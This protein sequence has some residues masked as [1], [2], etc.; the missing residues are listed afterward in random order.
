MK[1]IQQKTLYILKIIR[2][3]LVYRPILFIA[4]SLGYN[5]VPIVKV[6]KA[7]T[8]IMNSFSKP[9]GNLSDERRKVMLTPALEFINKESVLSALNKYQ[10]SGFFI[11]PDS[12]N[13]LRFCFLDSQRL[14]VAEAIATLC[15]DNFYRLRYKV[16]SKICETISFAKLAEDIHYSNRI[17]FRLISLRANHEFNF[18]VEFWTEKNDHYMSQTPNMLSRK[19]W[20]HTAEDHGFFQDGRIKNYEEFL[21]C[22]PS[23]KPQFDIDLVFTWVNSNDENWQKLYQKHSPDQIDDASSLARFYSR[24]EL[25]FALRSWDK[26]A[27]FIRKVH[28]VSNCAPPT[29]L[30]LNN[31]RVNWVAHEEIF[32]ETALPTFSSHAIETR[33]HKISGISN[34]FIYSNDDFLL[35]RNAFSEDFYYPNGIAKVRLEP[36]GMVNGKAQAG[37]PDYLNAA[38]NSNALIEKELG[39]STTQLV[40]HSP[41]SLRK[42]VLLE[43]EEKF[44]DQLT[45]TMHNKFR[46]KSD[47]AVTGYLHAHYAIITGKAVADNTEVELIQQN[48]NFKQK[49]SILMEKQNNPPLAICINDG[50]DSH[51]NKSWNR[52]VEAFLQKFFPDKSSFER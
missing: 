52:S 28:I 14:A 48:H 13:Y 21:D 24:D 37:Q 25:K 22:P 15:A 27:P 40:T 51:L 43:L 47:V 29:W 2:L 41:Q 1:N 45:H 4:R 6:D 9:D 42:D 26:F 39:R 10:I 44:G 34:C 35:V 19:L 3:K 16:Q 7:A 32:P 23:F 17:G 33:L 31:E 49:F 30:N 11:D 18:V 8:A 46:S 12:K 5:I 38:R 50:A 20:K 36:Y